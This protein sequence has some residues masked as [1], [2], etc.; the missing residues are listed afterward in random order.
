VHELEATPES[1]GHLIEEQ[2]WPSV[3]AEYTRLRARPG[4]I[5]AGVA[6]VGL[7]GFAAQRRR[8][9]P[10]RGRRQSWRPGHRRRAG[11][12]WLTRRRR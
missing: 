3:S 2:L 8:S 7:A 5:A 11:Q 1:A 12:S 10:R 9:R 6:A 4:V